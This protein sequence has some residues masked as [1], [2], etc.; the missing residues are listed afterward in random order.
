MIRVENLK[1]TL[2]GTEVLRDVSLRVEK[3]EFLA[4]I[5]GSGSGKSVL[6]KHIAGLMQPDSGRIWIDDEDLGSLRGRKLEMIRRR[7]GFVFQSG[8]LFDSMTV[9]DNLAFPLREK[10]KLSESEIKEKIVRELEQVE[11]H[12]VESKYPAQLSGGMVKRTA[13]ARALIMDPEIIF[14]DEPTTGLDPIIADA[15]LKLFGRC[16]QR[17][18]LTGIIV[19]HRIPQIFSIAQ[20]VAMLH[21]GAIVSAPCENGTIQTD[22]R[23]LKQFVEGAI[24]GPV[25]YE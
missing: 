2:T 18:N 15:M 8:A 3:G 22:N 11:L 10:T 4:L 19:S 12:G 13:L 25:R 7:Y 23:I 9:Y 14:F 6:L 5:G 20:K 17:L 21:E 24:E 16:Q 1:K